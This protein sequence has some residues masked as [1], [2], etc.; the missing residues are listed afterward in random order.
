MK[1]SFVGGP[2]RGIGLA[3]PILA[4]VAIAIVLIGG[5]G[6]VAL[7]NANDYAVE[8][9]AEV[10][11]R[12]FHAR[13]EQVARE[14]TPQ[15][16]WQEAAEKVRT[17][18]LDW[19]DL[20]YGA[21][22]H[23]IYGYRLSFVLDGA[24]RP[25]Y[26]AI[27]G[28]RVA[29]AEYARVAPVTERWIPEVRGYPAAARGGPGLL[30]R[31][32]QFPDGR[33]LWLVMVARPALVEGRPSLVTVTSIIPDEDPAGLGGE[34][35]YL[36]VAVADADDAVLAKIAQDQG[37]AGLKWGTDSDH[38]RVSRDLRDERGGVIGSLSWIPERPALA[39]VT[40]LTP[41]LA[42]SLLILLLTSIA[43]IAAVRAL[44]TAR[45][46]TGEAQIM[47][48]AAEA[49]LDAVVVTD[50]QGRIVQFNR[51]AEATFGRPRADM[52]G[53]DAAARL[54]APEQRGRFDRDALDGLVGARSEVEALRADGTRFPAEISLGAS[55]SA[56]GPLYIAFIRDITERLEQERRLQD[57]LRRAEVSNK[58]KERFLAVMSHE[59]RTPLNGVLGVLEL[60]RNTTLSAEQRALTMVASQSGDALLA[61]ISDILDLSRMESGA[62]EL[63]PGRTAVADLVDTAVRITALAA[64]NRRNQVTTT[65]A[66]DVPPAIVADEIRLR[67]VLINLLSNAQKFTEGG[68]IAV[69]VSRIPG[70]AGAEQLEVAVA[71]TG[72]GLEPGSIGELFKD[73]SRLDP[74]LGR[75]TEGAGLGLAI[76]KRIV[77]AMDG[78]IG[79]AGRPGEGSRFWFRIPLQAAAPAAAGAAAAPAPA[80]APPLQGTTHAGRRYRILVVEDNPVN[81][82]VTRGMLEGGGHGVQTA[83]NGREA[84]QAVQA[85][86]FDAILMDLS[87]PDMDGLEATRRIRA[88]PAPAGAVPIIALTAHVTT[89]EMDAALAAGV[90][91]YLVKPVRQLELLAR[92]AS[93]VGAAPP[94]REAAAAAPAGDPLPAFDREFYGALSAELPSGAATAILRQFERELPDRLAELRREAARHDGDAFAGL[95][96]ALAGSSGAVGAAS[97]AALA[98]E[99]ERRCRSGQAPSAMAELARLEAAFEAAGRAVR[100][101]LANAA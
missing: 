83:V 90:N 13:A 52:L 49:A 40:Q 60:L 70:E 42:V 5:L 76:S 3:V 72:I 71:D 7:R 45:A 17:R 80:A 8:K 33:T 6:L 63:H 21:Y 68:T 69:T 9:Q 19:M 50:G 87:M 86:S 26:G 22:L 58:A 53:G 35:P 66:P 51:A 15:V 44:A 85:G 64:R 31:A 32:K 101:E 27:E 38:G 46:A 93:V 30:A 12:A 62:L 55:A 82:L 18:D 74:G 92:I 61:L 54:I 75:R 97:L 23:D 57:A 84:L 56:E 1:G 24:D 94:Q 29:P 16:F 59:I 98:R 99:L 88:L 36:L 37:Y 4:L 43:A 96:H 67:Q 39:F 11:A 65:I 28:R 10:L 95:C 34:P 73:F 81:L 100:V 41:A 48:S 2:R 25:V 77:D 14:V 78:E 91:G 47:A 89:A 20:N 79:V